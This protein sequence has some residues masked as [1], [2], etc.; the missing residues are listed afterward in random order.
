MTTIR[1]DA[2]QGRTDRVQI[3]WKE[4]CEQHDPPHLMI[5]QPG[6]NVSIKHHWSVA[7]RITIIMAVGCA[8]AAVL[9][10]L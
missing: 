10:F 6:R 3:D 5:L 2:W 1:D 9:V 4:I 8:V 7:K